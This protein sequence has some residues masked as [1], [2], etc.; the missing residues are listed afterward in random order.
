M[1]AVPGD[2]AAPTGG[3]EYARRLL[4]AARA[5]GAALDY[6]P[7]PDLGPRPAAATVAEALARL[8]AVPADRALLVDG[9][10]YG[11]L[12]PADLAALNAPVAALVHHPLALE[13]GLDPA[14]AAWLAEAE[15]AALAVAR[16]VVTTSRTTADTLVA[17]YAVPRARIAVAHPGTDR[18]P[19]DRPP[20]DQSSADRP[21]TGLRPADRTRTD[22]AVALPR[23]RRDGP[24]RL[25]AVG[26]LVPRKGFDVLLAALAR[27]PGDWR[28][29]I[30]G[31]ATRDPAHAGALRTRAETLGGRVAFLGAAERSAVDAAYA[32]HD[33]FVLAS[34]YEGYGMAYTEALA[35]GLPTVG[36]AS[37]AVAEA[38]RGGAILVQPDDPAALATALAPLVVDPAARATA[39]ERARVAARALPTWDDTLAAVM[40]ALAPLAA[41]A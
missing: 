20:I 11:T 7:L 13:A 26:S 25:L 35:A 31:S 12:P 21:S 32:E 4:G 37:G 1:L 18:P 14:D 41:R 9:L 6:L 15:T 16:Q 29:T 38:T 34:R 8:A 10:A 27:V 22:H 40:A 19:T 30:L 2:L 36:C 23:A 3:Y 17:R 24:V 33:V 5:T 28:L 39:A